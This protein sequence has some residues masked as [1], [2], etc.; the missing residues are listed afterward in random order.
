[1]SEFALEVFISH[2]S[3]DTDLAKALIEVLRI[4]LM[5][6]AS[7]IRCTSVDGYRLP[8][9]ADSDVTIRQEVRSA[10]CFVG[11]ITPTSWASAYV[12]FEL[13]ARWGA[14]FPL[15]P[16]LAG[17]V[18]SKLGGPLKGL[19]ALSLTEEGQVDQLLEDVGR[20]LNRH[21]QPASS[22]RSKLSELLLLARNRNSGLDRGQI[23][24]SGIEGP[25]PPF[26]YFFKNGDR[27]NPLCPKCIQDNPPKEGFL[28]PVEQWNRGLRRKCR[29]CGHLIYEREM[30]LSPRPASQRRPYGPCS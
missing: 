28:T 27:E 8:G 23:P 15:L 4:A 6:P 25:F 5:I 30:D 14:D 11:L 29:L 26:G 7:S 24:K 1:M 21:L 10:R 2:S 9:G 22:F 16:L 3:E 19:N 18:P 12:L 17:I 13:G 20:L